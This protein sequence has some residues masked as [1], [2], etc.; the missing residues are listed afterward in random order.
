MLPLGTSHCTFFI[1][2][3]L[4]DSTFFSSLSFFFCWFWKSCNV[5]VTQKTASL[6]FSFASGSGAN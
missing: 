5:V 6:K 1:N 2:F 4:A 3:L